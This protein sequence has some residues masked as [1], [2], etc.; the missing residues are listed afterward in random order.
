VIPYTYPR[1]L[2][3][4]TTFELRING[5]PI[6]ALATGVA[7]FV[8]AALS[9]TDLP[10]CIEVTAS[11]AFPA[12]DVVVRPR[13]K[14]IV[15]ECEG[16]I[17]RF[18]LARVEKVSI[19][20]G[21]GRRPLYLFLSPPEEAP[22]IVE[23]ESVVTFPA[24]Q[25]T[26]MPL[27]TL[28][29]GQT[30]YL[31]GGAVFKGRIHVKGRRDVRIC[32][33]GIIDGSYYTRDLDGSL[34]LVV[35]ESCSDILIEGITLV[36]PTGW[37]LVLAACV[38]VTVRDLRQIGEVVSS[39]G[40][41]VVGSR[42]VLIEDC[43]LH[44][45]DDC[46]VVKAFEIGG[47]NL[48]GSLI[49]GRENVENILVRHCTLANWTAGNAVEIGHELSVDHVRGIVFQD[50]DVLHVH[51]HGAVFSLHNYGRALVEDVLFEDIRIEH[52]FDKFIDFRISRSRYT[53][54]NE[55]PGCIRG[56]VLRN[57]VWHR[58]HYCPGYTTS[59][60]GG[61]DEHHRIEDVSFENIRLNDR[62]IEDLE[63][64]EIH[65]RHCTGLRLVDSASAPVQLTA[66]DRG[67]PISVA[68]PLRCP[69]ST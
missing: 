13:S 10:A 17:V 55:P 30:L 57:I 5:H 56:I 21:Y 60:I 3:R 68:S 23:K 27:L 20:F 6:D 4:S 8:I 34:P 12:T 35:M 32:G 33:H 58:D 63:E 7:D 31:P 36:R 9:D 52:C 67:C 28:E 66:P 40:I 50:I 16:C 49:H 18:T 54:K 37:M 2:P 11:I 24:G 25:I 53:P 22:P 65:Q 51:G 59:L 48:A 19:D 41:D 26:E 69:S 44:N 42:D 64:L 14:N 46:V 47:M 15:H 61:W 45:N 39:D 1:S 62:V 38:D 29:D 43:F